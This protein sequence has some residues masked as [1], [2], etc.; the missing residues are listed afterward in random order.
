M[1]L[2]I[3]HRTRYSYGDPVKVARQYLRLTPSASAVQNVHAW[4]V[5]ASGK[6]DAWTDSHGNAC[7]FVSV[8]RAK[9]DLSVTA[10]GVVETL[11]SDGVI[12]ATAQQILAP[13]VYLRNSGY[14]RPGERMSSYL[15]A[16]RTKLPGTPRDVAVLLMHE[17]RAAIAYQTHSTHVHTTGED[18]MRDGEGVCQ[19]HTHVMLGLCRALDIPARYV[20]GYLWTGG[21]GAE[22]VSASHA[23]T[24]VYIGNDEWLNLD[25]A[26]CCIADD[27]YVRLACG[28]DYASAS[29]IHGL[30]HG[31][32]EE[33][34]DVVITMS[35]QGSGDIQRLPGNRTH[36]ESAPQG[37]AAQ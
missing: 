18:A 24:E 10:Q 11:Q 27:R 5:T 33:M 34:M 16:L 29:P 15:E 20:S 23:W 21:D 31:G 2:C 4:T 14:T 1:H 26:N 28:F 19:D 9:D 7:H 22:T 13:A 30:R 25:V 17:I 32:G 35:L 37:G 36:Q 6:L 12:R 3:E 8:E